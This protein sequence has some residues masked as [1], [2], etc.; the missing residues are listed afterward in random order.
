[1][2][3]EAGAGDDVEAVLGQPR[4]GQVGLDAAARVEK[5]RIGQPARR[6]RHIVGADPVERLL[7]RPCRSVRIW[8]RTTGR[9]C[10]PSR[11][12]AGARR[13]PH[14]TSS[15]GPSNRRPSARHPF[16]RKPV[17]PLPAELRA[18][19]GA[20][21][22]QAAHR[23]ARRCAGARTDIP[24]AESRSCSACHR[25][26]AC[27][28]APSRRSRCRL[29]KR[30]ISTTQRSSGA[31]PSTTHCASTQ[32]APPPEAMPKALKPAP[33]NMFAHSGATPRMKLPSGVKLSGP[34]IICLTPTV[35]SAGTR[36]IACAHMLLEMIE[37]VV[38]QAELPVVRHV[39]R[40][41]IQA[42]GFGS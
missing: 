37:I 30:R 40:S 8:R 34:L 2:G 14:R 15:A 23:A 32:P 10:R 9:R 5:L 20:M 21:L 17:R 22:L 36:A 33:T 11:A 38:E 31:S 24:R 12:R 29:E 1:M 42:C 41:R 25:L 35:S 6:L 27:G 39:A 4:H 18:E 19:H 16:G 13:R 3:A 26:R 7:R 28:R